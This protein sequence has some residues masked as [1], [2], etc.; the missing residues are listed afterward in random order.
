MECPACHTENPPGQKYCGI[1]GQN[2]E[3]ECSSCGE[4]NPLA[5][6]FCG[7]CGHS[8]ATSG[9][10]TLTRSGLIA[11]IDREA[12]AL[13]GNPR[14]AMTGKPFSLF[15]IR[16]DLPIF[17]VHWNELRSSRE[18]QTGE[19]ALKHKT[20]KKIYVTIQWSFE[21][22][23][24]PQTQLF[25][26]N[27]NPTG[28]HRSAMDQLQHQ[29]DL[30]NLIYS[31]AD[32]VHTASSRHLD[33]AIVEGLK[34]I[35]LFSKADRCFIYAI[36]R[37]RKNLEV[38]Y[39]WSQ[40]SGQ[41]VKTPTH[42]V[43]LAAIKRSIAR[44]RSERI[45]SIDDVSKLPLGE[46]DGLLAAFNPLP[47]SLMCQLIYTHKRPI[48]IV[49]IAKN[50]AESE[51]PPE[52]AALIKL[53]GHLVCD[54]LTAG[55]ESKGASSAKPISNDA[56][57]RR[58]KSSKAK[59][60]RNDQDHPVH[61]VRAGNMRQQAAKPFNA[62]APRVEAKP[63]PDLGRPMQLEKLA[64]AQSIERQRVFAREDGLVLL[65]CPH[66]GMRESVTT[67][68]FEML[69][70]AIT[71]LCACQK[72]FAAVLEKRGSVRKAVHLEGYFTIAGEYGPNDTKASI[73]GPMVVK[74][75]SKTGLRF[76]S[77]RLELIR[78]GDLLMVRF[79]LDN[80]N[81]ALIHKKAE[82]VSIQ[83][84]SVGCRFTEANEYDI[85]LGFYF[86]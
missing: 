30:L 60:A 52:C 1:C 62:K 40:P 70:N 20:G 13:L 44:L 4:T 77:Q 65:T 27:L 47:G 45:Y 24:D 14:E 57:D 54:L 43:P 29:Q 16:E 35:C 5:F 38:R 51:W 55:P 31:L 15:V 9:M 81:K 19:L 64:G 46:R 85:T 42:T 6:N 73:W 41:D 7:R 69:G 22:R 79:N 56:G 11:E 63:L 84:Q 3:K 2:L 34:K 37:H 49:G 66:C 36:N 86:I 53:F 74:N 39:Q 25:H 12:A 61:P 28:S 71:A 23:P 80:S 72:R 67:A 50:Q 8:L 48:A 21:E 33:A 10:I 26:L 75:L 18:R 32:S 59:S 76:S 82:V 58:P 68:R 78:P 83:K 17:F